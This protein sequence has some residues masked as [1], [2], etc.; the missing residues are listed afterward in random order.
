MGGIFKILKSFTLIILS[1]LFYSACGSGVFVGKRV[2]ETSMLSP[3]LTLLWTYSL[4]GPPIGQTLGTEGLV[5]QA[6]TSGSLFAFD[7]K[8]GTKIGQKSFRS[9]ISAPLA[10][11]DAWFGIPVQEKKYGMLIWDRENQTEYWNGLQNG[12]MTPIFVGDVIIVANK[13]GNVTALNVILNEEI[14]KTEL[15][16]TLRVIPGY[17]GDAIYVGSSNGTISHFWVENGKSDWSIKLDSAVRSVPLVDEMGLFVATAN[18]VVYLLDENNGSIKWQTLISGVPT[19]RLSNENNIL[20][21]G[22]SD[23]KLYGIEIDNGVVL[24]EYETQGVVTG[25][26]LINDGIVYISS[27]DEQIYAIKIESG[28]LLWKFRLDG[29][30]LQPLALLDGTILVKSEKKTLYAFGN[31]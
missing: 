28:K 10:L 30:A 24:W 25:A 17:F 1:I 11:S 4:D 19:V 22:A 5:F 23:R 26:P 13:N 18:G 29:P 15:K 8:T 31:R 20:V 7:I 12:C 14:W 2:I 9:L 27:S 21:V 6:T 3:P 16:N